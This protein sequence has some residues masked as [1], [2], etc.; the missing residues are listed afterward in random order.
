M[1]SDQLYRFRFLINSANF[2]FA[3][4]RFATSACITFSRTYRGRD[5]GPGA[6]AAAAPAAI[7]RRL[8]KRN[9]PALYPRSMTGLQGSS[10]PRKK[11]SWTAGAEQQ[12]CRA[13]RRRAASACHL[14]P[15]RRAK[16]DASAGVAPGQRNA[17]R[18]IQDVT[19][20]P[21]PRANPPR[22]KLRRAPLRRHE[23]SSRASV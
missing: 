4:T 11:I 22:Q 7:C 2:G 1:A 10:C 8:A 14:T 13:A 21:I 16:R 6:P 19:R 9:S 20:A 17:M 15:P 23:R 12:R 18:E 3:L 5:S